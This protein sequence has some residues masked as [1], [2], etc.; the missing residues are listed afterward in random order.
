M[1][2]AVMTLLCVPI[3]VFAGCGRPLWNGLALAKGRS[4]DAA[5]IW[6]IGLKGDFDSTQPD[7][8]WSLG[9][10]EASY[11]YWEN[12][13]VYVNCVALSPVFTYN[14]TSQSSGLQFY[15]EGGIGISAVSEIVMGRRELSSHVLFEDRLGIGVRKGTIDVNFRYLHYSNAGLVPPNDGIDI[16][17]LTLGIGF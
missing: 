17:L 2:V 9:Y 1:R 16:L 12:M 5:D 13:G 4:H 11:S 7:R 10:Y 15:M 3:L 8:R 6:R 14:V